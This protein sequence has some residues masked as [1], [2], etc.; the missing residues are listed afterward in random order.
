MSGRAFSERFN[1]GKLTVGSLV[2]WSGLLN[3]EGKVG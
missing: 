3:D 1:W 2:L